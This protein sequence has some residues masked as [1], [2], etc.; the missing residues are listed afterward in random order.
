LD[1]GRLSFQGEPEAVMDYYNALIAQKKN[2]KI[3]Q[4]VLDTGK[5][6][7]ISG[8]GEVEIESAFISNSKGEPVDVVN[9]GDNIILKV[10]ARAKASLPELV[11]G[12]LIKDRLGQPIF[13]T[14]TYHLGLPLKKIEPNELVTYHF[15][16]PANLGEGSYAITLAL[17][18]SHSHL[19]ANYVWKDRALLLNIVNINR[20]FFTGVA[21]LPPECGSQR[22]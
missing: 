10:T 8:T 11:L 16:F 5:V 1:A 9:V 12:Y 13:G 19:T 3:Q 4:L 6:E 15:S 22:V 7:T 17:H 14:N 2:S 21:W 18:S 20:R